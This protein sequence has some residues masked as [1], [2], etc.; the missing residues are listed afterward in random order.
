MNGINTAAVNDFNIVKTD[1][2]SSN[3]CIQTIYQ[4]W[5]NEAIFIT[6]NGNLNA[7]LRFKILQF[8][9]LKEYKCFLQNQSLVHVLIHKYDQS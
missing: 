6:F 9:A 7:F 4:T 2:F 3:C 5:G 8:E 1:V